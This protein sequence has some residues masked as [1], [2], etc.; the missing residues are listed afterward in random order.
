M[1]LKSS[2]L[3]SAPLETT[4]MAFPSLSGTFDTSGSGSECTTEVNLD[5]YS[6]LEVY[7]FR[8]QKW[9]IHH[10]AI[11]VKKDEKWLLA[12]STLVAMSTS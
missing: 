11:T 1:A 7:S 5:P 2:E 10:T 9:K 12:W 4:S 8:S 3:P 6:L